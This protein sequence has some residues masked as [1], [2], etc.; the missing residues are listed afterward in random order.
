MSTDGWTIVT[1]L[2]RPHMEERVIRALHDLPEFPG[3][4]ITDVRGQGRGRGAGGAYVS[5]ESDLSFH[6]F[7]KIEILC[8]PASSDVIRATIVQAAWTG[9][10]GDG[11]VFASPA[12]GFSRIRELGGRHEGAT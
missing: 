5:S 12:H 8:D 4:F 3:F 7:V 1:A 2:I 11:I 6:E 9:R 10:K